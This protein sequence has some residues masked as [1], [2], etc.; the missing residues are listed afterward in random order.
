M[1]NI[2]HDVW[3]YIAQ[4][5]PDSSLRDM[6]SVNRSLFDIAM[7]LRYGEVKFTKFGEELMFVLARLKCVYF[8]NRFKFP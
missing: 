8:T 1:P 4:F 2:P 6:F 5:I 3:L 7:N